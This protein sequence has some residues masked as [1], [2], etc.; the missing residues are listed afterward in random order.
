M[1]DPRDLI[2]WST[3]I[4]NTLISMQ[5]EGIHANLQTGITTS[6][7]KKGPSL[8]Q[9]KLEATHKAIGERYHNKKPQPGDARVLQLD[10]A[11]S[12][13]QEDLKKVDVSQN[14]GKDES[15]VYK[16][17]VDPNLPVDEQIEKWNKSVAASLRWER[18]ALELDEALFEVFEG[19]EEDKVAIRKDLAERREKHEKLVR[20]DEKRLEDGEAEKELFRKLREE[21]LKRS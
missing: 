4:Q 1:A 7:A 10:T 15:S 12:E 17:W 3:Q 11:M 5:N 18:A 6:A 14:T 19:S 20:M 9:Q 8:S 21:G 13:A 16:T 2:A